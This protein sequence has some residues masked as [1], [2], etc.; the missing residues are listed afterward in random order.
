MN[1]KNCRKCGKIFNF[2]GGQP[3]CPDCRKKLEDDFVKAKEYIR[4]NP[5]TTVAAVAEACEI[6]VQQIRQ[7]LREE[8]LV[9]GSLEGSDLVCENCGTKILS[10]RFCDKC[11]NDVARGLSS[12]IAKPEAPA[13][14]Q[15]KEP[16]GNK[17]RFLK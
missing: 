7:W 17:M 13:P 6:E 12:A 9:F 5:N 4:E 15:K 11:K 3:I 2:I 10:G 8:R 1:V 14:V 16:T